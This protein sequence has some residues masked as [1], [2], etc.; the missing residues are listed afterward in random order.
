MHCEVLQGLSTD[1]EATGPLRGL[2]R[3]DI[4]DTG[5]IDLAVAAAANYRALRARGKTVRKT[6]DCLIAAFR[7]EHDHV[8]RHSD[9]DFDAFDELLAVQ[10]VHADKAVG[11]SRPLG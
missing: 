11:V 4:F 6:I 7:L 3:F 1:D 10:V 5:G 9:R 2:Q 8:L